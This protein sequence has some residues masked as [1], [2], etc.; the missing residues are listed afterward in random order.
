MRG[1]STIEMQLLRILAINKGLVTGKPKGLRDVYCIFVRKIYELVYT[2][3]FFAGL[4]SSLEIRDSYKYRCYLI[5]IYLHTVSTRINGKRFPTVNRIFSD[6]DVVNWPNELLFIAILG[7]T[8]QRINKKR[9]DLYA[10]V[11]QKCHLNEEIIF[12]LIQNT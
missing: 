5:Y 12:D 6:E 11:I 4:K 8:Y 7:L 10:G 1:Y 3:M 9:V 2:D